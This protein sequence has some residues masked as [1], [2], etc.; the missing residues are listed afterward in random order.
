[1][2]GML[3]VTT[4]LSPTLVSWAPSK[5]SRFRRPALW[6]DLWY[7]ANDLLHYHYPFYYLDAN[8]FPPLENLACNSAE[9]ITIFAVQEASQQ[10]PLYLRG[11]G[12]Q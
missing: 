10:P 12:M 9:T 6:F 8:R 4:A 11:L 2:A 1:M 5:F 7:S 3:G